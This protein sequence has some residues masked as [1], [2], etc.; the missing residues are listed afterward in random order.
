MLERVALVV[1]VNVCVL[2]KDEDILV[3]AV[4][5]SVDVSVVVAE[6][7]CV[8][9]SDVDGVDVIVDV[10]VEVGGVSQKRDSVSKKS[11]N[12]LLFSGLRIPLLSPPINSNSVIFTSLPIPKA[13]RVTFLWE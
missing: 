1:A 5:V 11:T 4:V 8:L 10:A 9:V 3:D 7:V 6:D 12:W 13:H 2:V